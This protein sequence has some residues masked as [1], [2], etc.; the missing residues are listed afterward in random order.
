MSSGMGLAFWYSMSNDNRWEWRT[1]GTVFGPAE[2][3]IRVGATNTSEFEETYFVDGAAGLS[4]KTRSNLL[5]VKALRQTD[6]FGLEHWVSLL[7]MPF[8]IDAATVRGVFARWGVANT[9]PASS[10]RTPDAFVDLVAT[11]APRVTEWVVRK[12]RSVGELHHCLVEIAD[13]SVEGWPLRTIAVSS[14]TP[15]PVIALVRRLDLAR[16][17]NMS[18]VSLLKCI[19]RS[20]GATHRSVALKQMHA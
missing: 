13:I 20:Q 15:D 7:K 9:Q 6:A 2:V 18:Y 11:E 17:E 3:Q 4:V 14:E 5:C 19:A 8:P 10:V 1:F 12:H 16:F